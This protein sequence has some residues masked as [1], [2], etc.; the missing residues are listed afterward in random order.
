MAQFG[1]IKCAHAGTAE[2]KQKLAEPAFRAMQEADL[3]LMW[4]PH[5]YGGLEVE[6]TTA[7]RVVEE[8]AR[9][10]GAAAWNL[11]VTRF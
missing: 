3:F 11:W 1:R 4:R 6:P 7:F 10:N 8:V 2:S 9:L 5:A